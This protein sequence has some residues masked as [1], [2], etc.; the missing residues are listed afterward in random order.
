MKS[1]LYLFF[2]LLII[3]GGTF[4]RLYRLSSL[5]PSLF[6]DEADAGYQALVFNQCHSDYFGHSY[7]THFQSFADYRT[8]LYIYSV[9]LSQKL[10]GVNDFS[11]RFPAAF[12]GIIF[13]LALYFLVKLTTKDNR[14]SLIILALASFSP[15][16]VHYSR[17]A[18]EVT[19]MLS[20]LTLGL[21]F[22][23]FYCQK[24]R[25]LLL[26]L[27]LLSFVLSVYFY[28]TAKLF[29][30]LLFPLILFTYWPDVKKIPLKTLIFSA[31]ISLIFIFPLARDTLNGT[32]GYRFSYINIFSEPTIAKTVDYL[33][34]E[35]ALSS[36]GR[37][38][39]LRPSLASK[40]F[41]NKYKL[42]AQKFIRNYASA[43]S[44]EF[45]FIR[46]DDN[47]RH[48]FVDYGYFLYPSAVFLLLGLYFSLKHSSRIS[49]LFLGWLILAPIPF[50]L[51][52][53]SI[54]PHA[55]RLI[56]MLPPL[57]FFIAQGIN[58]LK[59][60]LL[61]PVTLIYLAFFADFIFFYFHNYPHLSAADWSINT[62]P[63]IEE[64]LSAS[65]HRIF[66][67][68][69]EKSFLP[70]FL[71]YSGHIPADCQPLKSFQDQNL[72]YFSGQSIDNKYFF[73]HLEWGNIGSN[74]N[75]SDLFV[76]YESEI[77]D[78]ISQNLHPQTKSIISSPY[79]FQN[80]IYLFHL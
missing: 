62:K 23:I 55:T 38:L 11:V 58:R 44:P 2:F 71:F 10:F 3:L 24:H 22:W 54:G 41:H 32:A 17:S 63:A 73:G 42:I 28:S 78:I 56:I 21:L 27:S 65:A 6:F 16:S 57:I 36:Q 33:R 20:T 34:F 52:R 70:F 25:P 50:S 30:I 51:T 48:G 39:G 7:P 9:A 37:Q 8:P 14:L 13:S 79:E 29:L 53:D 15:W 74:I 75:P 4:L 26:I 67:S 77:P 76:A 12:Y 35:D 69:N 72:P 1:S 46:G 66:F 47:R 43:F 18:F 5:P 19:G 80:K 40:L 49:R 45:L 64:A 68:Q 61:L 59:L 60:R 31:I